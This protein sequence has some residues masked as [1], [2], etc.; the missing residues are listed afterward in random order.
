MRCQPKATGCILSESED[1]IRSDIGD[2]SVTQGNHAVVKEVRSDF[3]FYSSPLIMKPMYT[4]ARWRHPR[5]RDRR[6]AIFTVLSTG[7]IDMEDGI[8][9]ELVSSEEL[10]LSFSWPPALLDADG[11]MHALMSFCDEF[12][13]GQGPLLAQGI[14]DYTDP[15]QSEIGEEIVSTCRIPLPFPVKPD[16]DED[17]IKFNGSDSTTIYVMRFKAFDQ[18][19]ATPKKRLVVRNINLEDEKNSAAAQISIQG[20]TV[21]ESRTN[22][23][24]ITSAVSD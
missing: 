14:R 7:T 16:F 4:M 5:T 12:Q 1:E 8:K 23:K 18:R 19:F 22:D 17:I 20:G 21:S 3:Q 13:D 10:Q 9:A 11:I 6:L 24:A 15:L 2:G